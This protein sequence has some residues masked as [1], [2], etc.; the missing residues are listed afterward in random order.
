MTNIDKRHRVIPGG[1]LL[2]W[3]LIMAGW[4]GGGA[5]LAES[6]GEK[7]FVGA[8]ACKDCHATEFKNF[9]AYAKKAHS[10]SKIAV[11]KRELTEQEFRGC[12]ECHTTGYGQPGGFRSEGE[13]PHLKDPGC[14]VCHGPGSLHVKSEDAKDIKRKLNMADCEKCHSPERIKTFNYKPLVFG[15]AH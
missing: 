13:T 10:Y 1:W 8:A 3:I 7:T 12:L 2:F 15:G 11:M 14:E 6:N 9:T 5:G 4:W